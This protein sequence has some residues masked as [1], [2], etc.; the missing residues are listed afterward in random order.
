MNRSTYPLYILAFS[1]VLTLALPALAQERSCPP[2]CGIGIAVPPDPSLPPTVTPET[3][4]TDPGRQ[5]V[6][7]TNSIVRIRFEDQTPFIG[8]NG[9][10]IRNFVVNPGNRP[11]RVRTDGNVCTG[12]GCKYTIYDESNRGRPPR[13]PYIVIR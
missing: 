11:I 7:R 5:I 4:V 9:N 12:D 6:F 3:L 13:D 2:A 10:P 1:A 8:N